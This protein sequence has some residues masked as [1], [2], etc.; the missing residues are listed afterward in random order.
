M[1][2]LFY[3]VP[4]FNIDYCENHIK[5]CCTYSLEIQWLH[6]QTRKSILSYK[7]CVKENIFLFIP[8]HYNKNQGLVNCKLFYPNI[9]EPYFLSI[10]FIFHLTQ[11]S[12]NAITILEQ[13]SYLLSVGNRLFK[14]S[15][16]KWQVTALIEYTDVTFG[17][18]GRY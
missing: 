15:I 4:K 14:F 12:V 5:I 8:S 1:F 2:L 16:I 13:V 17:H 10:T 9:P 6:K 3:H 11:P 18:K 7:I